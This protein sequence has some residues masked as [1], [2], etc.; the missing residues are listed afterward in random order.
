MNSKQFK[1]SKGGVGKLNLQGSIHCFET[2]IA[3]AEVSAKTVELMANWLAVDFKDLRAWLLFQNVPTK[4]D[5]FVVALRLCETHKIY[6][7]H[8]ISA[9]FDFVFNLNET[10]YLN[11]LHDT[12]LQKLRRSGLISSR[13]VAELMGGCSR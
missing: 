13:R 8:H 4:A 7:N 5:F 3:K 6:F 10:A 11:W 2:Y 12:F 9:A 1:Q